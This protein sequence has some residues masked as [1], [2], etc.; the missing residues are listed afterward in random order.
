MCD[1]VYVCGCVGV[2]A[3]SQLQRQP[4]CNKPTHIYRIFFLCSPAAAAVTDVAAV[5]I[6][7]A[8]V[9]AIALP[10]P[11]QPLKTN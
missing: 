2:F 10:A 9:I 7:V 11:P 1:S 3:S 4:A 5:A 6:A 8:A